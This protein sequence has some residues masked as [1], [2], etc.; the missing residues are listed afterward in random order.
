[1]PF[2]YQVYENAT[3]PYLETVSKKDVTGTSTTLTLTFWMPLKTFTQK[4]KVL[5]Q[6]M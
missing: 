6:K 4:N 3:D 5:A 1:V 2:A